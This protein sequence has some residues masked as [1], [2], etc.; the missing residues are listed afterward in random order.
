[1]NASVRMTSLNKFR[2]A[3]STGN[4]MRP[5]PI[6]VLVIYDVQ[7]KAPDVFQI[8]FIVNFGTSLALNLAQN[9]LANTRSSKSCRGIRPSVCTKRNS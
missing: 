4:A 7:V 3:P 9:S 8:P 2:A 1:M 5:A 6:K